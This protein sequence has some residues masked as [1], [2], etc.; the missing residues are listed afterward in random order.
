MIK[1]NAAPEFDF[2]EWATLH[3]RDPEAFE[4]RRRALLAIE[5]AKGGD[6]AGPVRELLERL[7]GQ[8][9]GKSAA[10]RARL[11]M[12]AMAESARLMTD[13]LAQL[14]EQVREHSALQSRLPRG[15]A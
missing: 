1:F 10:E 2:D 13:R 14:S 11:S 12:L 8:L 9:E 7:E 15:A 3:Q 6:K 5:L 4:A